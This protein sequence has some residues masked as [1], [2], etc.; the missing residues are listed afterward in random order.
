[1]ADPPKAQRLQR[2]M[3]DNEF[4]T[5]DQNQAENLIEIVEEKCRETV[6]AIID[7]VPFK[8]VRKP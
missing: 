2:F 4:D 7:N 3:N 1:M 5:L 6:K 8:I